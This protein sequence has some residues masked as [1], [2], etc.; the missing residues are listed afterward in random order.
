LTA[1]AYSFTLTNKDNT[2]DVYTV[3]NDAKGNVVFNLNLTEVGTYT[4]VLAEATRT[5]VNVT[6][7]KNT[8][9]ATVKVTD[10]LQGNLKAEVTYGTTD[11]KAPTF[12][13]IY[14]PSAITVERYK[15][16]TDAM[17]KKGKKQVSSI[18]TLVEPDK[19]DKKDNKAEILELYPSAAEQALYIIKSDTK[20]SNKE[21]IQV[22]FEEAGYT[23]EEYE[24]DQQNVA[25]VKDNNGPVFNVSVIYRLEGEDLLKQYQ[26]LL[27]YFADKAKQKGRDR[28]CPPPRLPP[29]PWVRCCPPAVPRACTRP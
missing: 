12:E 13:N 29:P 5:D 22:F 14:T 18:Y 26:L 17:S 2:K 25:A 24:I 28:P 11:G 1:D 16:F 20:E 10:D 21:K 23:E 3:K 27:D 9:T 7:D 6:Y 19:L 15:R 8:Y 4:Y